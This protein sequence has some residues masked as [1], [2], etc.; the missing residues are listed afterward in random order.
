MVAAVGDWEWQVKA[1]G[2]EHHWD[3]KH[4]CCV[5]CPATKEAGPCIYTSFRD[6]MPVRSH[7]WFCSRP[8]H[9]TELSQVIG[10]ESSMLLPDGMHTGPLG[11]IQHLNGS[12]AK[13]M[14]DEGIFSTAA[15]TAL[16]THWDTLLDFQLGNAYGEFKEW[17]GRH[18]QD[19]RAKWWNK[20]KLSMGKK[21][22]AFCKMK[23][24]AAEQFTILQ[25]LTEKVNRP[26]VLGKAAA[27]RGEE[28]AS[29]RALVAWSWNE[30]FMICRQS[31]FLLTEAQA[32]R[33]QA[34]GA[35]M[36]QGWSELARRA[37]ELSWPSYNMTPKLHMAWHLWCLASLQLLNP[38]GWWC[39]QDEDSLKTRGRQGKAAHGGKVGHCV[40]RRFLV[41][42]Y[43]SFDT[44]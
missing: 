32:A 35:G 9:Q 28:Y 1:Y 10:F 13:E 2:L 26:Q 22:T 18:G 11:S 33:A 3:T 41:D 29:L 4:G 23:G 37:C 21:K 16:M 36:L 39:F 6:D 42:F 38:A 7:D 20:N 25:F 27:A 12:L 30:F 5:L 40:L 43:T 19:P 31:K 44:E 17:C 15:D 24:K 8:C 14:C 34:C